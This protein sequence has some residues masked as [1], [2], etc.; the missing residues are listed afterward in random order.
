LS[1]VRATVASTG[2]DKR[3]DDRSG[4]HR[5]GEACRGE[6]DLEFVADPDH[7]GPAD[8]RSRRTENAIDQQLSD[9]IAIGH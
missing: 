9:V 4:M 6:N 5:R 2:P 1:T 7:A 8:C 3:V